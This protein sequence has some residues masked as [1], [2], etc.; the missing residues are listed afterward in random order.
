MPQ[1]TALPHPIAAYL[2]KWK[3]DPELIFPF[4]LPE[5][6]FV[7]LADNPSPQTF[8][9]QSGR[10]EKAVRISFLFQYKI[11]AQIFQAEVD[12]LEHLGHHRHPIKPH[13]WAQANLGGLQ[14]QM[15]L[16][17]VGLP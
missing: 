13:Y 8:F 1:S 6:A 4:S 11:V 10:G 17:C 7:F 15:A 12:G 5:K 14:D 2:G 16:W 9:L 3:P